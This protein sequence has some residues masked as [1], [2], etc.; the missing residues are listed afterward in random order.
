MIEYAESLHKLITNELLY[1]W[2]HC[3]DPFMKALH[4]LIPETLR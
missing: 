2:K 4:K 1:T 3:L